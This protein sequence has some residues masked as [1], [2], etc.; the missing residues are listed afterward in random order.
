VSVSADFVD[1]ADEDAT[2]D[3]RDCAF[4]ASRRGMRIRTC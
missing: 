3:R 4:H 1:D 2:D